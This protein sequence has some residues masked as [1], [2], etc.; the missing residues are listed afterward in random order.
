MATISA[1]ADALD[2]L[3]RDGAVVALEGV[4]PAVGEALLRRRVRDLTLVSV[5]P[6]PVADAL[7]G[8][9]CVTRLVV[10]RTAGAR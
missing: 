3:V 4:S 1:L 2:A 7:V 6:G 9:G 8:A 10:S 5:D